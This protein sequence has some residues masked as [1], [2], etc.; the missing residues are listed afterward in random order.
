MPP[1]V[2]KE[3]YVPYLCWEARPKIKWEQTDDELI[4]YTPKKK[5]N[6]YAYAFEIKV[7]GKL[8]N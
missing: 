5:P 8:I 6:K 2:P 1:S 3:V 7:K 4:I